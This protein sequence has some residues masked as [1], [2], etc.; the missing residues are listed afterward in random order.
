[1]KLSK[2]KKTHQ[3]KTVV[4]VYAVKFFCAI[5][6]Y[7]EA[8]NNTLPSVSIMLFVRMAVLLY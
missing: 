4:T 6:Y 2:I 1:M 3:A 5:K 7:L 8:L